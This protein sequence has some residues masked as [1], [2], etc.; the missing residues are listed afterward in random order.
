[1]T[2]S[3]TGQIT[4]VSTEGYDAAIQDGMALAAKTLEHIKGVW[5]RKCAIEIVAGAR[6]YSVTIQLL[7]D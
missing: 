2:N 1:M 6:M 4:T 7:S 3:Q 5:I